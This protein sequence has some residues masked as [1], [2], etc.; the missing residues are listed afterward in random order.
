MWHRYKYLL[1]LTGIVS[2]F[3]ILCP[4]FANAQWKYIPDGLIKSSR[5][6][7]SAFPKPSL[8]QLPNPYS[9]P[10]L[11]SPFFLFPFQKNGI[12]T[13]NE[14]LFLRNQNYLQ[15]A[16]FIERPIKLR[17]DRNW[18]VDTSPSTPLNNINIDSPTKYKKEGKIYPVQ[19]II[20]EDKK[21]NEEIKIIPKIEKCEFVIDWF[22]YLFNIDNSKELGYG[23]AA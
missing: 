20:I 9:L 11:P 3:L 19:R 4:S 15:H 7:I 6:T 2:L 1:A 5:L 21:E 18:R 23:Y 10:S 12:L 17:D 13:S 14:F 8:R 16:D 22:T